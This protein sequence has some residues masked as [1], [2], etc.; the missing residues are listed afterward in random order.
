MH[1][2]P[3]PYQSSALA[4]VDDTMI[5]CVPR[6]AL[7]AL[8][9]ELSQAGATKVR[10]HLST[11]VLKA[12]S[13][14]GWLASLSAP[15]Q[16]LL[17]SLF[18]HGHIPAHTPLFRAG[19][20]T[21]DSSPVF[22]LLE[23]SVEVVL[24]DERGRVA[25]KR[26]DAGRFVGELAPVV[27][28]CRTG[29][30]TTLTP[31]VVRVLQRRWLTLFHR[32]AASQP[33][34][35][36]ACQ[37][38]LSQYP[39]RDEQ[40]LEQMDVQ[41]AFGL[42]CLKSFSAENIEFWQTAVRFRKVIAPTVIRPPPGSVATTSAGSGAVLPPYL[43][44]A[45]AFSKQEVL[46]EAALL[47]TRYISERSLVQI[48]LK[49]GVRTSVLAALRAGQ[50]RADTFQRAE[51]EILH[52]MLHDN[53][54]RFKNNKAFALACSDLEPPEPQPILL[55]PKDASQIVR[56]TIVA[57][58]APWAQAMAAT[59][60]DA[61]PG[62]SP[63]ATA[64]DGSS[65]PTTPNP[66]PATPNPASPTAPA[67]PPAVLEVEFRWGP[68]VGRQVGELLFNQDGDVRTAEN[69]MP[70]PPT[71]IVAPP[72]PSARTTAGGEQ[73]S[74]GEGGVAASGGGNSA[75]GKLQRMP[76]L[77]VVIDSPFVGA[78]APPAILLHTPQGTMVPAPD[79]SAANANW[80]L[81][82]P[83]ESLLANGTASDG[84]AALTL[85]GEPLPSEAGSQPQSPS[86]R[87][88]G[89]AG[90]GST[91]ARGQLSPSVPVDSSGSPLPVA[92][93]SHDSAREVSLSMSVAA[94]GSSRRSTLNAG[95]SH[96]Q[97]AGGPQRSLISRT[98]NGGGNR[99]MSTRHA[100]SPFGAAGGHRDQNA[101]I[102]EAV[103]AASVFSAA[104]Q[105]MH[106]QQQ[107]HAHGVLTGVPQSPHP[108]ADLRSG[109]ASPGA[110]TGATREREGGSNP[111]SRRNTGGASL[112]ASITVAVKRSHVV[113]QKLKASP[114]N[115]PH[116]RRK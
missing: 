77:P 110:G 60:P 108:A 71:I 72:P 95:Q 43:E 112:I 12:V 38:L 36:R 106:H 81:Q 23:G 58:D 75:P 8:Y 78:G 99:R 21:V 70:P 50:L 52:L 89:R 98:M 83:G 80:M 13:S 102:A 49:E 105:Q 115:V 88:P 3:Q 51:A 93:S 84:N 40:L 100:A 32:T 86:P 87:T 67:A 73:Q 25:K 34:A 59:K 30:V 7:D 20:C 16:L 10:A 92:P 109:G 2:T 114:F 33:L 66:V 63:T 53:W 24:T 96:P 68:P 28:L 45:A 11:A 15:Q 82:H 79:N 61:Q 104:Q 14:A 6:A 29:T 107:S 1:S 26:V 35:Q 85:G 69:E 27:G 113:H 18:A 111:H 4:H 9:G 37:S 46:T 57:S 94:Q 41:S 116:V 90:G 39:V 62:Q 56:A 54:A 76:S 103:F 97:P 5:L 42:D 44:D 65:L 47:Y 91:S 55:V 48:N 19:E 17:S 74:E 101:L 31:C 22:L 64:G